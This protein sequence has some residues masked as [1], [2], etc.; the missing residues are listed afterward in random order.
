MLATLIERILAL[1]GETPGS[2]LATVGTQQ[3][4]VQIWPPLT[5]LEIEVFPTANTYMNVAYAITFSPRMIP[6]AFFAEG[7]YQGSK[8]TSA[9]ITEWWV[10]NTA[11][12]FVYVTEQSP[13]V[14]YIT[15]LTSLPQYYCAHTFYISIATKDNWDLIQQKLGLST[16]G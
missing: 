5:R 13:G 3:L 15:N 4:E 11:P 16:N 12:T 2:S 10:K 1:Q 6:G 14:Y 7:F 9:K 8:L